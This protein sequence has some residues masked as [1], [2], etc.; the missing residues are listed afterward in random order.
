MSTE[1]SG[2]TAS[3]VDG[4]GSRV[5]G[6]GSRAAVAVAWGAGGHRC[7]SCP[8]LS[9]TAATRE[10]G[11]L[12]YQLHSKSHLATDSYYLRDWGRWRT[13]DDLE[14]AGKARDWWLCLSHGGSSRGPPSRSCPPTMPPPLLS[15]TAMAFGGGRWGKGPPFVLP[16][17]AARRLMFSLPPLSVAVGVSPPPLPPLPWGDLWPLPAPPALSDCPPRVPLWFASGAL[18]R[19]APCPVRRP[20]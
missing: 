3:R 14:E 2:A 10:V 6:K 18:P 20:T 13:D 7:R 8:A 15:P 5:D 19:L 9:K 11:I 1:A 4:K 12:S 16:P 17:P